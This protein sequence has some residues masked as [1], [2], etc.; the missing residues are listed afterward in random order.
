[1]SE[2]KNFNL[3]VSCPNEGG[4]VR[5]QNGI[6]TYIDNI[7]TTGIYLYED[8]LFR[9]IQNTIDTPL[10]MIVYSKEEKA[11]IDFPDIRD[12]HDILAY[13]GKLYVVSTGTNEV[14][15]A[16]AESYEILNRFKFKGKGDAWHLNCLEVYEG[17]LLLTAFGRFRRHRGYK[18]KTQGRGIALD[19]FT[20]KVLLKGFS[21][22]HSPKIIDGR[23]FMCDS[24]RKTVERIDVATGY[25][26]I[27]EFENY[28]RGISYS[29]EY[30]FVGISSSRNITQESKSSKVVVLDRKTFDRVDEIELRYSEIYGICTVPDGLELH[31]E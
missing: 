28:T 18:G 30:I 14:F 6:T 10:K 7:S 5:V 20:G 26:T 25:K 4:L 29:D 15:E 23:L 11:S 19:L 9:C 16:S 17:N 13:E 1:M 2:V 3:I 22:P 21:Q 27:L 31:L 12:V 8:K 24:E